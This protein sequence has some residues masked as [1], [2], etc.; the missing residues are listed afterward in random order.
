LIATAR[1]RTAHICVTTAGENRWAV[2]SL[3]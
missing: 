2:T 1:K 3:I